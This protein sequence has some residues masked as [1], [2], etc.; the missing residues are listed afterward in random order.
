MYVAL[1]VPL[2]LSKCCKWGFWLLSPLK[3]NSSLALK[4]SYAVFVWS[5]CK[6]AESL[7][8]LLKLAYSESSEI[9]SYS[10]YKIKSSYP[11]LHIYHYCCP[12]LSKFA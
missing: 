11:N 12:F 8:T 5:G 10:C 9:A 7:F 2:L 4:W 3:T 1:D 6:K